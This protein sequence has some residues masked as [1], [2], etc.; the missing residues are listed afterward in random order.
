MA[1]LAGRPRD[2][3]LPVAVAVQRYEATT[4]AADRIACGA[5][6]GYA[7]VKYVALLRLS[8]WIRAGCPGE[9]TRLVRPLD[10]V[11]GGASATHWWEL[12]R[13]L[14]QLT[15]RPLV[16]A[17]PRWAACEPACQLLNRARRFRHGGLRPAANSALDA[18]L[19]AAVGRLLDAARPVL[20]LALVRVRGAER[21]R[22]VGTATPPLDEGEWRIAVEVGDASLSVDALAHVPALLDADAARDVY[23]FERL[24]QRGILAESRG[25]LLDTL[26]RHPSLGDVLAWIREQQRRDALA[27]AHPVSQAGPEELVPLL[28]QTA[29]RRVEVEW[30]IGSLASVPRPEIRDA[31]AARPTAGVHVVVLAGP[32][33]IGKTHELA[34]WLR[35]DDG[36][37]ALW[38]RAPALQPGGELLL[39]ALGAQLTREDL[40]APRALV[41]AALGRAG[42]AVA[43][44]GLSETSDGPALAAQLCEDARELGIPMQLACSTRSEVLARLT[45]VLGAASRGAGP[46][47][48]RVVELDPLPREA[49]AR[50]WDE[51]APPTAPRYA[52]LTHA[53]RQLLRVPMLAALALEAGA[54][55]AEFSPDVLVER[56]VERQTAPLE[57]ALLRRIAA[58]MYVEETQVLGARHLERPDLVLLREAVGGQGPF[59]DAFRALCARGL[60]AL[61]GTF[62]DPDSVRVRLAHDR[63]LQWVLSRW[64]CVRARARPEDPGVQARGWQDAFAARLQIPPLANAVA[65]ALVLAE[66]DDPQRALDPLLERGDPLDRALL[67]SAVAVLAEER[68]AVARRWL[69]AAWG[70]RG[71]D[72]RVRDELVALAADVGCPE[73]LRAAL[74]RRGTRGLAL[75]LLPAARR[76]DPEAVQ[77]ALRSWWED[78]RPRP[79]RHLPSVL[80]LGQALFMAQIAEGGYRDPDPELAALSRELARAVLETSRGRWIRAALVGVGSWLGAAIIRTVPPGPVDN[81]RELALFLRTPPAT[82]GWLRPLVDAF[83]EGRD[84]AAYADVAR[85]V[86]VA[87][88]VGPTLLLERA[89][90][91]N[92]LRPDVAAATLDLTLDL[93]RRA[94]AA[95]PLPMAAQSCLYVYSQYLEKRPAA[96]DRAA[97]F[98]EFEDL[99][100]GWLERSGPEGWRWTARS[101]ARYKA[102]HVAAHARL[103]HADRGV[104]ARVADGL[105]PGALAAAEAGEGQ[106]ALDL[107]D[108][109]AILAVSRGAAELAAGAMEPLLRDDRDVPR[110][111]LQK[112]AEVLAQIGGRDPAALE[113]ALD[114]PG[115]IR[116]ALRR[117]VRSRRVSGTASYAVFLDFDDAIV[118]DEALRD[119]VA[120][121][122]E[123][124]LEARSFRAIVREALER[125]LHHLAAPSPD[126]GSAGR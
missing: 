37:G 118:V 48:L 12:T 34:E 57:R 55:S 123:S 21:Q 47:T 99:L 100:R 40:A 94:Q 120:T 117:T 83:R 6:A 61:T 36:R 62:S 115:R 71:A 3:P 8:D 114:G 80:R 26:R 64:L 106:R 22:L 72:A 101:G 77:A 18:E 50:L 45:D 29:L 96:P 82:R 43:L 86:A 32:S 102:L 53:T 31:L 116:D 124:V 73:T 97:R 88:D 35:R 122:M 92:V 78:L 70:R 89:L 110:D 27:R 49:A 5:D 90:I 105:W 51:R 20:D 113:R 56:F 103:A 15:P 93:G 19:Q 23:V 107:L 75:E 33:G 119:V 25:R 125:T 74:R 126:A 68:P 95:S 76:R 41:Q 59:G 84:P 112:A 87:T 108:D 52:E 54:L 66:E 104:G 11:L 81:P 79:W 109:L 60:V 44:D 9:D 13:A 69:R 38:L 65:S 17:A 67:R 98:R 91:A 16:P 121:V 85:R 111:V 42:L 63:I 39:R 2:L 7:I 46:T 58:T 28:R 30:R 10:Q 1:P 4:G 14:E 24:S